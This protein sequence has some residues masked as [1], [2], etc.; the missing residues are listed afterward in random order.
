VA[1]GAFIPPK[2]P[3]RLFAEDENPKTSDGLIV[4][5]FVDLNS[6][7][8]SEYSSEILPKVECVSVAGISKE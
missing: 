1:E 5:G 8:P 7:F 2:G 3:F 6:M 4:E